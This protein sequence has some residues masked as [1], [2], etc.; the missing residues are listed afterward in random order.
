MLNPA[1]STAL[2]NNIAKVDYKLI[3]EE[4]KQAD[5]KGYLRKYT[6]AELL[7]PKPE[8]D[9]DLI[10][11]ILDDI[12]ENIGEDEAHHFENDVLVKYSRD[13]LSLVQRI[14]VNRYFIDLMVRYRAYIDVEG[15]S[16]IFNFILQEG[17]HF[18]W[19][20]YIHTKIIPW[21]KDYGVIR[22]HI[23][24]EAAVKEQLVKDVEKEL[25]KKQ[26]NTVEE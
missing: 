12:R 19:W 21:C 22:F 8:K 13:K 17:D 2:V 9:V 3:E 4:L 14:T 11:Y 23:D 26:H 25:A 10:K 1:M 7:G 16:F 24:K 5:E 20:N 15:M 6:Q 18:T